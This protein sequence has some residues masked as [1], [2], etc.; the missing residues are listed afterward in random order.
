M[1]NQVKRVTVQWNRLFFVVFLLA[2][3]TSSPHI[4]QAELLSADQTLAMHPSRRSDVS[5]Q[6]NTPHYRLDTLFEP[7]FQRWR[8]WMHVQFANP[9]A[10]PLTSVYV[11][12]YANLKDFNGVTTLYRPTVNGQRATIAYERDDYLAR[13]DFA[14]PIAVGTNVEV[15]LD[16][17]TT[18]PIN[19]G[20][21]SYGAFNDDGTSISMAS[22]YPLIAEFRDGDWLREIPDSKGDL[23]NSPI[24]TYDVEVTL[25]LSHRIVTTGTTI[26]YQR[27]NTAHVYQIVSGLQR[28]FTIVATTLS[29]VTEVVAGTRINIYYPPDQH[30]S[31]QKAMRYAAQSLTVFNQQFGQ[32]PYNEL[33]FVAV[34]ARSFYGVEYPGL[35]LLQNRI[36][37]NQPL[38]ERI[39]AH[40]VAHQW[41]YNVV[42]NDVQQ[43]AWVDE[44]IATYAQVIYQEFVHGPMAKQNE[45]AGLQAQ[46]DELIKRNRDGPIDRPMSEFTLYTFNA[47]AYVKGALYLDALRTASGDK[48]FFAA[49]R[50]YVN[51]Y[52]YQVVDGTALRDMVQQQ[53]ACDIQ[54]IYQRWVLAQSDTET[55]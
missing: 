14:E 48:A 47:I 54:P 26:K 22:A 44:S 41:F 5:A 2:L 13:L 52:A 10:I 42:G 55:E 21:K 3:V 31:A 16:F 28:D 12:L 32:Y 17:L 18:T 45:L 15:A 9:S 33:D 50:Q 35:I 37:A 49:L 36:F 43:H 20:T 19:E 11:R 1:H 23:V 39:I 7:E 53:C 30:A 29:H 27:S 24:A 8:G 40:E 51:T 34:D 38:L 25:P 4:T 46:Y 6:V